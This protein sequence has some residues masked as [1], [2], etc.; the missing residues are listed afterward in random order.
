[1]SICRSDFLSEDC[2]WRPAVGFPGVSRAPG[3]FWIV[4]AEY[5][6]VVA[7]LSWVDNELYDGNMTDSNVP[8]VAGEWVEFEVVQG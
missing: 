7:F 3:L 8:Y 4:S 2:G 6:E 5:E 1:V